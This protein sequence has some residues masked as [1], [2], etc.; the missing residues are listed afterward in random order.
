MKYNTDK[1]FYVERHLEMDLSE[2]FIYRYN[3]KK[4]NLVIEVK[5]PK[6]KVVDGLSYEKSK[7]ILNKNYLKENTYEIDDIE[8]IEKLHQSIYDKLYSQVNDSVLIT[9]LKN[10][11]KEEII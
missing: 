9:Y 2:I 5:V 10:Y 8:E 11:I 7:M 3:S 6:K 1:D 4:E